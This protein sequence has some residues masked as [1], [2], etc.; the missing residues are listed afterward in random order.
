MDNFSKTNNKNPQI[1]AWP[2]SRDHYKQW[3]TL[4]QIYKT[5]NAVN[6]QFVWQVYMTIS[7]IFLHVRNFRPTGAPGGCLT[8][9]VY[10]RLIH[11]NF[12]FQHVLRTRMHVHAQCILCMKMHCYFLLNILNTGL[13]VVFGGPNTTVRPRGR[14]LWEAAA[15]G[16]SGFSEAPSESL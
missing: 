5:S 12:S 4:K 14:G 6:F 8:L 16:R 3:H 10:G 2:R 11:L 7:T 15:R 1:G 13:T 9:P